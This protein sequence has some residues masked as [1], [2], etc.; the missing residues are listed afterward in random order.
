MVRRNLHHKS[1]GFIFKRGSFQNE[2]RKNRHQNTDQIKREHE[3]LSAKRPEGGSKQYVNRKS[4]TA[5]HERSH[6]HGRNTIRFLLH[7]TGSHN[8]RNTASEPDNQRNER[9]PGETE[10]THHAV[11]HKSGTRH[12]ARVLKEGQGQE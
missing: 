7:R 8:C 12:V 9:F 4:C 2:T 1:S 10:K 6:H 3:V 11:H 5:A